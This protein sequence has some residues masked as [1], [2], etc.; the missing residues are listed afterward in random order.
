MRIRHHRHVTYHFVDG[1]HNLEHFVVGD[2]AVAVNVVE[3][4]GPVE[5]ILHL[6]AASNAQGADEL[7]EVNGA[8]AVAVKN[9]EYIVGKG[10]RVAKGEE[11][12]VNLLKLLLAEQ[13]RGA[14]LKEACG[15]L[16][17][18]L[19]TTRGGPVGCNKMH[20]ARTSAR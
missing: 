6:A 16:A 1:F 12:A 4:K 9:V 11:L 14:V 20:E 17:S 5:L 7:F 19:T 18:S 10:T 8:G 3:L 13:T 2:L 15:L